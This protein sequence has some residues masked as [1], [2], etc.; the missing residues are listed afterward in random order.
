MKAKQRDIGDLHLS[1]VIELTWSVSAREFFPGTSE[2]DWSEH[3]DWLSAEGGYD[4]DSESIVLPM[5]SYVVQ[6]SH[7]TILV[8]TCLV[9]VKGRC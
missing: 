3:R 6:T 4:L 8:D 5:Q 7:H 2:E 1:R 9:E